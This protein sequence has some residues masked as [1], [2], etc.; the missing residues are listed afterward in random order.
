MRALGASDLLALWERGAGRHALD[1]SALLCAWARP[2]VPAGRIADLPLGA[3]TASLLRLHEASFG[4][5]IPCHVDCE[6]CGERLALALSVPGLLQPEVPEDTA[7]G[8][9]VAG[10]RVRAPSLRDLAA[11]VCELD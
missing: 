6:R 2:D 9:D 8:I 4:A 1:R 7:R 10:L 3:V 11:V 5:R